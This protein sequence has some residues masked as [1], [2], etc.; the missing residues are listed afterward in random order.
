MA[1]VRIGGVNVTVDLYQNFSEC[2]QLLLEQAFEASEFMLA[3]ITLFALGIIGE[4]IGRIYREV[5]KRPRYAVRKIFE[6]GDDDAK[7]GAE[8]AR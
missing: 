4:Y 2:W 8:D 3:S 6:A 7:R 5:I 1:S